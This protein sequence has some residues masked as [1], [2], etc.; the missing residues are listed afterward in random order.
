VELVTVVAERTSRD[1]VAVDSLLYGE[2]PAD[3]AALVRLADDLTALETA[4]TS[5][6][7]SPAAGTGTAQTQTDDT[8]V[9]GA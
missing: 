3:D 9:E 8:E 5:S 2:P 7:R 1:P 4:L 6:A